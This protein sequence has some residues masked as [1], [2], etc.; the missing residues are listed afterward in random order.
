MCSR[1]LLLLG[2]RHV[3][4]VDRP[5]PCQPCLDTLHRGYRVS[6]PLVRR[7]LHEAHVH[8]ATHVDLLPIL[9]P[10]ALPVEKPGFLRTNVPR[11]VLHVGRIDWGIGTSRHEDLD[12][13]LLVA[14]AALV[15]AG[16]NLSISRGLAVLER[17]GKFRMSRLPLIECIGRDTD[18]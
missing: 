1:T 7:H 9:S 13:G 17:L 5:C 4:R 15:E 2:V 18:F 8:R 10:L 6:G 14:E 11:I 12:R 16:G 3:I